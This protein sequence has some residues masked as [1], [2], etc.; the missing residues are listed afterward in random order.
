MSGMTAL[1]IVL[2]LA[3][4]LAI[5]WLLADVVLP[6]T[7][8][9]GL[10]L[11]LAWCSGS[12]A[13]G[14]VMWALAWAE[15]LRWAPASGLTL[16][17][18][19]LIV[20]GL[21]KM[22]SA[23]LRSVPIGLRRTLGMEDY[24]FRAVL[25]ACAAVLLLEDV[26]DYSTPV[27]RGDEAAI[28]SATAKLAFHA[29]G[30][31]ARYSEMA[32]DETAGIFGLMFHHDYP[33][34]NPML[35]LWVFTVAGRIVHFEN[36]FIIEMFGLSLLLLIGSAVGGR[37]RGLVAISILLVI[38]AIPEFHLS[39]RAAVSDGIV[40]LCLAASLDSWLRFSTTR[41]PGYWRACCLFLAVLVWSKH[42]DLMLA[43]AVA[44]AVATGMLCLSIVS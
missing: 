17:G 5:G 10:R 1:E 3:P 44:A 34:L 21:R 33:P 8:P 20:Q 25:G 23:R 7:C 9:T 38:F 27:Y 42:E 37:V 30:F 28:W 2:I 11:V 29:G 36:R 19:A 26:A 24:A 16:A 22:R 39:S 18:V 31:N 4:P 40:A 41:E 35:Q 32:R 43:A 12:L 6:R 14:S 13:I 15:A